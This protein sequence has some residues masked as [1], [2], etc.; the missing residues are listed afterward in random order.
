[1]ARAERPYTGPY[2]AGPVGADRHRGQQAGRR[3][4]LHL[5]LACSYQI[6]QA[7]EAVGAREELSVG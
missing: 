4:H 3:Y 2:V 7:A 6:L 1:M 5:D